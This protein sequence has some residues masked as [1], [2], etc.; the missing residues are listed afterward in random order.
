M[1]DELSDYLEAYKTNPSEYAAVPISLV[2]EYY[3]IS[4]A[5]IARRLK[6]DKLKEIK[7]GKTRLVA[8]S[9]LIAAGVKFDGQCEVVRDALEQFAT[10]G[11]DHVFYAE[12]MTPIGLS[13]TVPSDRTL[14]GKILGAISSDT[15]EKY[16]F[17]LTVLVHRKT[18]G[19]TQPGPG[20]FDLASS[21]DYDWDD[22]AK[23]VKKQTKKVLKH[24]FNP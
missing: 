8:V 21:L 24:Y 11:R 10:Q 18:S 2:A 13:T 19:T 1:F 5:A 22:D 3:G 12:V 16:G 6:E 23:L 4:H 20:F 7:V 15:D 9:S 17:L 14:I